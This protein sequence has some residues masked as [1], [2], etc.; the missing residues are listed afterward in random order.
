MLFIMGVEPTASPQTA[1]TIVPSPPPLAN[2]ATISGSPR[3]IS[4]QENSDSSKYIK[5]KNLGD[6]NLKYLEKMFVRLLVTN[7]AAKLL[8]RRLVLRK[9][10]DATN[11]AP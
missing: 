9:V 8:N 10:H 3:P 1:R 11:L 6:G 2:Q 7:L 4:V 5:Q